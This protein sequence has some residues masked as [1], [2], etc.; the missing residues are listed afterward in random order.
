[1][2]EPDYL[3][4]ISLLGTD[5]QAPDRSKVGDTYDTLL[6]DLHTLDDPEKLLH[7][8]SLDHYY[9]LAAAKLPTGHQIKEVV[10]IVESLDYAPPQYYPILNQIKEI[11][12][13]KTQVTLLISWIKKVLNLNAIVHPNSLVSYCNLL[14]ICP[15]AIK[16]YAIPTLGQKGKWLVKQ[17]QKYQGLNL[18]EQHDIW[19]YGTP[20]QRNN[21]LTSLLQHDPTQAL[22]AL[23]ANWS[24]ETAKEKLKHLKTIARNLD[25][26]LLPFLE[27][28][29]TEEYAY[30]K[31]E[32][33]TNRQSREILATALL[34]LPTST[35]RA[36]TIKRLTPYR[37][38]STRGLLSKVFNTQ[39]KLLEIPIKNDELFNPEEMLRS[40]GIDA[41]SAS[42]SDYPTD[43]LYWL[44]KLCQ[45]IP[46]PVWSEITGATSAKVITYFLTAE[47]FRVS[48]EGKPISCLRKSLITLTDYTKDD[49]T[50]IELLDKETDKTTAQLLV[51]KLSPSAWE[52]YLSSNLDLIENALLIE[53]PHPENS[54][55]TYA[56]SKR[57]IDYQ[58]TRIHNNQQLSDYHIGSTMAQYLES[59]SLDYLMK[60]NAE[61]A[62]NINNLPYWKHHI[63]D[64]IYTTMGIRLK[65]EQL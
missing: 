54:T 19:S 32:T 58:L 10:P 6:D 27:Q 3:K 33:K 8:L 52:N 40:Y 17:H 43:Q 51:S 12:K 61:K 64:P 57:L 60:V 24:T 30:A 34:H 5:R 38:Q 44:S 42:M 63:F 59:K 35:L 41:Q 47:E 4:R 62:Q 31:T 65:I 45:A 56:F 14:T 53:S 16:E 49:Q 48:V 21:Y 18:Q 7:L 50:I 15:K 37:S 23:T 46:I 22:S 39:G 2:S 55:W 36:D 25:E 29:Y 26:S 28:L 11:D 9:R 1:M 13:Q 20:I